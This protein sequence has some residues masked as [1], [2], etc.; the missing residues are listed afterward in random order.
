MKHST[1]NSKVRSVDSNLDVT[2]LFNGEDFAFDFVIADLDGDHPKVVNYES[3]RAYFILEGSGT[4]EVNSK[5][6]NV[7]Q[8]DLITIKSGEEHTIEGDLRYVIVTSPP[9][10]P[11]NEEITEK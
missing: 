10:D 1:A 2:E 8:H 7:K 6:F 3:D 5:S 4:V 11:E 9:F